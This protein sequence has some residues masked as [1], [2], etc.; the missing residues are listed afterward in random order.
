MQTNPCWRQLQLE[1][2]RCSLLEAQS[3]KEFVHAILN[4]ESS[5]ATKV[6]VLLWK[7]WDERNRRNAG[8]R[9]KS[10]DQ[11]C[12]IV[13][14]FLHMLSI[15]NPVQRTANKPKPKWS[16]PPP[17]ILKINTDGAYVQETKK[18]AW[19]FIIRDITQVNTSWPE[20]EMLV[21]CRVR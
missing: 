19:G 17:G 20:P 3:A 8:E 6:T 10:V 7:W 9:P 1:S 4:L 18:G 13:M 5:M 11:F 14:E 2:V 16:R 15:P 21:T 12:Q